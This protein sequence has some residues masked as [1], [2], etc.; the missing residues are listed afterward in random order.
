MD[1]VEITRHVKMLKTLILHARY[2]AAR[3]ANAEMLKLYFV[4]GAYV[5]EHSRK[6]KW[7]TGVIE[8]ISEQLSR[9]LPGL[10][11]FSARNMRD[12]RHF[13][14]EWTGVCNLAA[15]GRQIEIGDGCRLPVNGS[16]NLAAAG[17]QIGKWQT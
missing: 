4:I 7:G 12:M 16:R 14:E 1:L 3:Q 9:E 6:G 8:A 13:C 15:A 5:S 10:R 17:C 2:V 11:G